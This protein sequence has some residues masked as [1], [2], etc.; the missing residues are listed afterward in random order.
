[1][2]PSGLVHALAYTHEHS[3]RA[4]E[5]AEAGEATEL[6]TALCRALTARFQAPSIDDP[7]LLCAWDDDYADAMREVYAQHGEDYDVCA[8]TA[9]ALMV[10]TPWQ[11]WDLENRVAATGADTLE[12]IGIIERAL[13]RLE[14]AGDTPHSGLLHCLIHIMEMSPEPERALSASSPLETLLP[15][16]GHLVHMPS[17][18]YVLCG[19]YQR[20]IDSNVQAVVAD[21][22]YLGNHPELGLFTIYRLHNLHFQ[23]YGAL[24]SGQFEAALRAA[25][26]MCATTEPDHL[27][28]EHAF[29]ANYLE[30]FYG[31]KAHVLVRFGKWQDILDEP[32]PDEP[33]LY[34]V[35]TAFWQ[36]AKG[37]ACAVLGDI[38]GA[39]RQ[40][41]ALRE[42]LANIADERVIFQ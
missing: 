24:F 3:Q 34:C 6:E 41:V 7:E 1:M 4:L 40:Q 10:R 36:Y 17:H 15:D 37:I 21:D 35:S 13:A 28:V 25:E 12:A 16:A 14:T 42:A 29:L 32:L 8:L 9:E 22:K 38:A 11:L 23:V 31:M 27:R 26:L 39:Q 33:D 2:S 30:A 19:Q 5:L 20:T 18:I